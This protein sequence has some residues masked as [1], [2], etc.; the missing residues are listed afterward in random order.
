MEPGKNRVLA[1]NKNTGDLI[2][3]Y[4]SDKFKDLQDIYIDDEEQ[5]LYILTKDNILGIVLDITKN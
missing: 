3:Q 5:K 1:F 4:N 2:I